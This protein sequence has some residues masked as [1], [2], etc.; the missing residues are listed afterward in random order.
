MKRRWIPL[1][2]AWVCGASGAWAQTPAADAGYQQANDQ[3]LKS[4]QQQTGQAA[5]VNPQGQ[6][7]FH[8]GITVDAY[9][10]DIKNPSGNA[11][12]SPLREND[13]GKAV[14]QGDVRTQSPE[15]DVTYLQGV[16]TGTNDRTVIARYAN[17]INSFQMGRAGVGYQLAFGDVVANFS[18]L[19]SNLG[20]RGALM[21]KQWGA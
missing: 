11:A 18:G 21:A 13:F 17:Q 5:S 4:W 8:G 19:S 14:F 3:V 15:Q 10:V 12:L 6:I 1:A 9:R 16:L 2:C 7:E 20:L